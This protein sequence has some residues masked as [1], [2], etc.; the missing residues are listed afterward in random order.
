MVNYD[1]DA[2]K[3]TL[4]SPNQECII[5]TNQKTIHTLSIEVKNLTSQVVVEVVQAVFGSAY[6]PLE[7]EP[8]YTISENGVTIIN[9]HNPINI[10]NIKTKFVSG[11]ATL[12][13]RYNG[14]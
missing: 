7:D 5:A 1:Y 3:A 2:N 13:I 14:Q 9:F 10:E 8:N 12:D 4:T 6:A 11:A